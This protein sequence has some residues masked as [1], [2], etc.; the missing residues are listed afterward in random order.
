MPPKNNQP[1]PLKQLPD[2]ATL[3]DQYRIMASVGRDLPDF[4][5]PLNIDL[6]AIARPLGIDIRCFEDYDARISFDRICRLLEALAAISADDSF[7]LKYGQFSKRGA[8]GPF[9]LGLAR[10]PSFKEMLNFYVKYVRTF[11][12]M[13][14][15]SAIVERD[16]IT[17]EWRHSPLITQCEQF[18]DYSAA[19]VVRLF[20]YHTD[21][22][23]KL[24]QAQLARRP[25][26]DKLLHSKV[27]SKNIRFDAGI[28]EFIF[29]ASALDGVNPSA[30]KAI[31]EYMK[32]QCE[33]LARGL[34][35]KK[36]IITMLKEDF[37]QNME[38]NDRAIGDVARRQGMSERTLQRRLS[39]LGT[40]FWDV[41]ES[42][43]D[44]LSERLLTGT[45]LPLSEISHRLGY[46]SQSAYTRFVKR[47]RGKTPGQLRQES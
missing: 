15:F 19:A 34:S 20:N 10:A 5:S 39:E 13:D 7:G 37:L 35:R 12:E 45:D 3:A 4:C 16:R 27:F 33:T 31:F 21:G 44:E 38:F 24:L 18:V 6:D 41:Y 46:S 11:T 42:T 40:S 30:D 2:I 14:F 32:Q 43:K 17:I 23:V 28:N 36:D 1:T 26:R 25:P 29:S 47:Q 8:A 22:H 9:S